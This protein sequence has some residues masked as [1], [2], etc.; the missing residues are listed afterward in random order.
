MT[1]AGLGAKAA[2]AAKASFG[3]TVCAVNG[4]FAFALR[5]FCKSFSP[6]VTKSVG[7]GKFL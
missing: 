1:V 4:E 7:R 5:K 2:A 6:S 3:L